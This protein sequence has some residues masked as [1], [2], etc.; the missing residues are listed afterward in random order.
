MAETA[1]RHAPSQHALLVG[2]AGAVAFAAGFL[3][4]ATV[5]PSGGS[6]A[7]GAGIAAIIA[8]AIALFDLARRMNRQSTQM[9][10]ALRGISQGLCVFD[11]SERLIFC[12]KRYCDI[13]RL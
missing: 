7:V 2:A 12:N 1:S 4:L 3:A 6:P 13:Y 11:G 10:R 8:M 5:Q 9:A